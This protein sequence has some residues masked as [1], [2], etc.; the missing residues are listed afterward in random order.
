MM[1]FEPAS[2]GH[3][4]ITL[5]GTLTTWPQDRD[6]YIYITGIDYLTNHANGSI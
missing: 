5:P 6:T 2:W 4:Y 3:I 1:G